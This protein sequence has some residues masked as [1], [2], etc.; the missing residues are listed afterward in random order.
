METSITMPWENNRNASNIPL[1]KKMIPR[2]QRDD[3]KQLF[4]IFPNFLGM[5]VVD[6]QVSFACNAGIEG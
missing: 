2:S 3:A 5:S 4:C 1:T 6:I